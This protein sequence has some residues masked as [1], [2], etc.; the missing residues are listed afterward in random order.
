VRKASAGSWSVTKSVADPTYPRGD[1]EALA[2]CF[3][4]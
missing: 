4:S 1:P 3:S 2:R